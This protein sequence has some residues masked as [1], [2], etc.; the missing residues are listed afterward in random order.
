MRAS[1]ACP[2]PITLADRLGLPGVCSLGC[3]PTSRLPWVNSSQTS[4]VRSTRIPIGHLTTQHAR[5]VR[6]SSSSDVHSSALWL[7]D[8]RLP[9]VADQVEAATRSDILACDRTSWVTSVRH[10]AK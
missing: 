7:T 8:P 2:V 4:S 3:R 5:G 1:W 10:R 6:L 9:E